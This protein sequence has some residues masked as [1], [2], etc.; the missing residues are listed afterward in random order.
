[1]IIRSMTGYGRG[2]R[3]LDGWQ[4][5]VEMR[6]VNHRGLDVR[7]VAPQ[8]LT[9][10]EPGI[11]DR[12]RRRCLRGRV[13]CRIALDAPSTIVDSPA[14]RDQAK[15]LFSAL[16]AVT[17]H[18]GLPPPSSVADLLAAGLVL[19]SAHAE[20]PEALEGLALEAVEEGL[21]ELVATRVKEGVALSKD[22]TGRLKRVDELLARVQ[23]LAESASEA[24]RETLGGRI[25]AQLSALGLTAFDDER[26]KQ[27]LVT[28]LDRSDITEELVRGRAHTQEL[29]TLFEKG[30]GDKEEALGKRVDFFL[31]ELHREANTMASKSISAELTARVVDVKVEVER[32]REQA[33]NIE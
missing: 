27:E 16:S 30:R 31:Q 19:R 25:R 12:V 32:M 21:T 15:Q 28:L 2:A 13:E 3:Q 1:M 23:T 29:Q 24:Y 22:F 8:R 33:Q 5:T 4:L 17:D 20:P 6:S 18:V 9:R 7:I 14:T 10:L 11:R 26:L